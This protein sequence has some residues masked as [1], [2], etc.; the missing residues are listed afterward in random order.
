M[1]ISKGVAH[2]RIKD[3]VTGR[4]ICIH[5][6]GG[7]PF[8]QINTT[9]WVQ[10]ANNHN[11]CPIFQGDTRITMICVPPID[12]MDMI[13]ESVLHERLEKEAPDFLADILNM[14]IPKSPDRLN[15]PVIETAD[16]MFA[17]SVNMDEME[18]FIAEKA[19]HCSGNVILFSEFYDQF[20]GWLDTSSRGEW[21]KI[22][23][24]KS[25]SPKTP[26]GRLRGTAQF[27]VGN[28]KWR[29]DTT[30]PTDNDYLYVLDGNNYL[31]KQKIAR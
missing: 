27:C 3:Y 31:A 28:I 26:K 16:K 7:T 1:D 24:G 21:S 12:P 17:Q 13:P 11:Y 30:A 6:K 15:I 20:V 25:F 14:D 9:H 18:M 4:E 2:N 29:T 23:V 5:P 19:E 22:R 10:C 8:H